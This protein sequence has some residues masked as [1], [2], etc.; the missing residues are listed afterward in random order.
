MMTRHS[1]DCTVYVPLVAAGLVVCEEVEIEV[2][3]DFEFTPGS[4][5]WASADGPEVSIVGVSVYGR[6]SGR[7]DAGFA[8]RALPASDPLCASI[9]AEL[10]KPAYVAAMIEAAESGVAEARAE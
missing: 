7:S 6:V 9:I 1:K 3:V 2:C 4:R 8:H 10:E 5:A